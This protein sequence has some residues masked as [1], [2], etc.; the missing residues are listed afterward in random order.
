MPLVLQVVLVCELHLGIDISFIGT[1]ELS[2]L[3]VSYVQLHQITITL[4]FSRLFLHIVSIYATNLIKQIKFKLV[5]FVIKLVKS[6]VI[7]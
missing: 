6:L 5:R 2:W 3:E 1:I 4:Y 7:N